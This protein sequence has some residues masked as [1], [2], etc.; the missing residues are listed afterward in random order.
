[1][2]ILI[3]FSSWIMLPIR[4]NA[5]VVVNENNPSNARELLAYYNLEQYPE[6]HLFY[7]PLFTDQY[8]GL[9]K[10]NPYKDDKPKYEK[11][12]ITELYEIVNKN[13]EKLEKYLKKKL[14]VVQAAGGLVY[15]NLRYTGYLEYKIKNSYKNEPETMEVLNKAIDKEK[16]KRTNQ[17]DEDYE[18]HHRFLKTYG[19]YLDIEKPSLISNVKYLIQY[20]LGYMYWRY[21]MWNFSGRQNDIQGRM[22]MHGNWISGID[23]VDEIHLGSKPRKFA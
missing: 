23:F 21:F 1:M 22:D 12:L 10:E 9:D 7:G 17:V 20:Q 19:Q 11:D 14:P 6:T 16:K 3:G 5:N 8:S 4:A 2:F 18:D 13:K 15:N